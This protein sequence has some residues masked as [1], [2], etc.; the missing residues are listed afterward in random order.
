MIFFHSN[1]IKSCVLH[2]LRDIDQ[3][4]VWHDIIY[5]EE[6]KDYITTKGNTQVN[7]PTQNKW[8]LFRKSIHVQNILRILYFYAIFASFPPPSP[9][10]DSSHPT[11]PESM[12]I[13]YILQACI[14]LFILGWGLV[15]IPSI[16]VY[17]SIGVVFADLV[18][19][20]ILLRVEP[21]SVVKAALSSSRESEPY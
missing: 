8:E 14:W 11:S 21:W 9:W 16:H 20:S 18:Q 6:E 3:V 19:V 17:V 1:W 7:V 4:T 12:S 5:T 15:E 2:W 10:S 13:L